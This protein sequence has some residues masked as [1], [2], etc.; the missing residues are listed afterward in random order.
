MAEVDRMMMDRI[1]ESENVGY[2]Y[3][4]PSGGGDRKNYFLSTTPENLANFLGSHQYDVVKM[5]ITDIC[6]RLIL[7][8][9]GGFIDHCPDQ[10]LCQAIIPY[11]A[12]IQMGEREAGE[13]LAVRR[14][15]AEAYFAAEDEA[16]TMA[17]CR[18]M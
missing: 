7:D 11:L 1:L 18:M 14:A 8:T 17:E 3:L 5:V 9:I 2:A 13:I 6:D 15:E 12:P 4:Y 10:G 16:V